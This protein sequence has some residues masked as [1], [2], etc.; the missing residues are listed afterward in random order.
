MAMRVKAREY[1]AFDDAVYQYT[2][3]ELV[4]DGVEYELRV[5]TNKDDPECV[6]NELLCP[7]V[8]GTKERRTTASV[9]M[10]WIGFLEDSRAIW[11]LPAEER[12]AALRAV[13]NFYMAAPVKR[14][15]K[16]VNGKLA[17]INSDLAASKER[18]VA[19]PCGPEVPVFAKSDVTIVGAID[20][21][22]FEVVLPDGSHWC[23]KEV[24]R[25]HTAC[26]M[27]REARQLAGLPPHPHI[28]A[29]H[30]LVANEDGKIEGLLLT[31][32][33]GTPLSSFKSASRECVA[34]WKV[35]LESALT[36]L[37][38]H[39]LGPPNEA[40]S[41]VWGDA[42]VGNIFI[43]AGDLV[44]MDFGGSRTHGWV[45][46]ELMETVDGDLQGYARICAWLDK[47]AEAPPA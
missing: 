41:R 27:V 6:E 26:E 8:K 14:Q 44:V 2:M 21:H 45:D 15:L 16:T 9:E 25:S 40:V 29:L 10:G 34:K 3:V 37:H 18:P 23:N 19:N 24:Y 22:V 43:N 13:P 47:I 5:E 12:T 11:E 38:A 32:L 33:T 46:K 36:H 1:S 35:Q 39:T 17:C 30:G 42:K 7:F 4:L 20:R 28:I 31:L